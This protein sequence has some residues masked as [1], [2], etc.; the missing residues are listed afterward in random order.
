[1]NMINDSEVLETNDRL[2]L[3]QFITPLDNT[4]S[5]THPHSKWQSLDCVYHCSC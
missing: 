3:K 5:K 1:M 2:M 4:S